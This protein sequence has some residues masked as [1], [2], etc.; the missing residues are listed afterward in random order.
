[1]A[2]QKCVTYNSTCFLK[3]VTKISILQGM[4][5]YFAKM[6]ANESKHTELHKYAMINMFDWSKSNSN[7]KR[8]RISK[9]TWKCLPTSTYEHQSH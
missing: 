7:S 5:K 2:Q 6:L 4:V 1:M 3:G 8:Q 9:P